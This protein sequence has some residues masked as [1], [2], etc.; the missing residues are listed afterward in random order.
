VLLWSGA[1]FGSNCGSAGL[2]RFKPTSV[3]ALGDVTTEQRQIKIES[4][5]N[6]EGYTYTGLAIWYKAGPKPGID[7]F[8][9][10]LEF[11]RTQG[12]PSREDVTATI[13]VK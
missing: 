9:F 4:G 13:T 6:C 2:P 7:V 10:T 1:D 3:A 11:P 8:T 5:Q 12:A